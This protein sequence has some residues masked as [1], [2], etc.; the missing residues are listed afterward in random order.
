[1]SPARSAVVAVLLL[2]YRWAAA[3]VPAEWSLATWFMSYTSEPTRVGLVGTARFSGSDHSYY[4]ALTV[5]EGRLELLSGSDFTQTALRAPQ[6]HTL[7]RWHHAVGTWSPRDGGTA[8]LFLDGRLLGNASGVGPC[9]L[10]ADHRLY[11]GRFYDDDDDF[12]L[13]GQIDDVRLWQRELS[14][15]EAGALWA[16]QR[17]SGA[18]LTLLVEADGDNATHALDKSGRGNN[19]T[20][21]QGPQA[22]QA[23]AAHSVMSYRADCLS[24]PGSTPAAPCSPASRLSVCGD[25]AVTGDEECEGGPWCTALC[26]CEAGMTPREFG[27]APAA[28]VCDLNFDEIKVAMGDGRLRQCRVNMICR[29]CDHAREMADCLHLLGCSLYDLPTLFEEPVVN[30]CTKCCQADQCFALEAPP[31]STFLQLGTREQSFCGNGVVDVGEACDSDAPMSISSGHCHPSCARLHPGWSRLRTGAYAAACGDGVVANSEACDDGNTRDNDG[32]NHNCSLLESGFSCDNVTLDAAEA[33]SSCNE[34]RC[35][36]VCHCT[37]CVEG[38]KTSAGLIAGLAVAATAVASAGLALAAL[39]WWRHRGDHAVSMN[40]S[41]SFDAALLPAAAT[42]SARRTPQLIAAGESDTR[43]A[44]EWY[45]RYP[46]PG[47]D[48][49]RVEVVINHS[50]E[51][52]FE[53][54]AHHLQSRS[55]NAAFSP[56]WAT[57]GSIVARAAC[58]SRLAGLAQPFSDPALPDVKV[59]PLWRRI[60]SGGSSDGEQDA[61]VDVW[62]SGQDELPSDS[63]FGRG[64][65]LSYEALRAYDRGGDGLLAVCWVSLYSAYPVVR[66]DELRLVGKGNHANYD[67]HFVPVRLVDY[68]GATSAEAVTDVGEAVYHDV[69]VFEAAQCLPRYL[70]TLQPALPASPCWGVS[71]PK[72]SVTVVDCS[73]Y[74]HSSPQKPEQTGVAVDVNDNRAVR[75]RSRVPAVAAVEMDIR[76]S[77]K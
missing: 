68:C 12:R 67:A 61:T 54:R 50:L 73:S 39:L 13:T 56:M 40:H 36:S 62:P 47:M 20:F 35:K 30:F 1:M 33:N 17:V 48:V 14:D 37:V 4:G 11:V 38:T 29:D 45:M 26:R 53:A 15:A 64:L 49:A 63:Q 23:L 31:N 58:I 51:L 42:G 66:G 19:G 21:V 59:L 65:P 2:L 60:S 27:C 77:W 76:V 25:G 72:P 55:G 44:L 5:N 24:C 70:V 9:R 74:P 71:R 43:K 3:S 41:W 16:G 52:M 8:R 22:T 46:V 10:D 57:D 32:C 34:V 7:Y 69:V 18:N 6:L 28:R 75:G